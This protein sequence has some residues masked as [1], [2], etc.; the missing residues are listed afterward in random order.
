M[1]KLK[2]YRK[3]AGFTQKQAAEQIGVVEFTVIRHEREGANLSKHL[4]QKYSKLYKCLPSAL[5]QDEGEPAGGI[6]DEERL[7]EAIDAAQ[8]FIR[9]ISL[10]S[11]QRKL[12]SSVI[13]IYNK[14]IKYH[15]KGENISM[16]AIAE[17]LIKS[18]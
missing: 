10:T 8:D 7:M 16:R 12:I 15:A 11:A 14:F 4:L 9:G 18:Q 5:L 13:E 17:I 3:K 1:N 2:F 6:I